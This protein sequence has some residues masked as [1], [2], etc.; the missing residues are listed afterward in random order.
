MKQV[1]AIVLGAGQRGAG[2][3][4]D[5]ALQ[6]PN[7]LKIVG[8]AEPRKDRREAFAKAHH[9]PESVC[10]ESWEEVFARPQFADCVFVCTQDKMHYIPVMTALR[11]GYHVLCE[12]PMSPNR[13]EL[14]AMGDMAKKTG[15]ILSICH[16][17][18]Y[19][20]FF[21]KIKE[22]LDAGLLGQL[23]SIQHIESVGYWHMAHSFVRGNWR[24]AEETSPMILAKC[25]HDTDILAWLAES[26]CVSVSSFGS[27]SHFHG[28]N[29]PTDA[30]EYC[31]DGCPQRDACPYYAP[32][33]YL[34]HPK[35]RPDGFVSV[36]SLDPSN[37]AVLDALRK[38]PYGRCVYR[39]DND[40]VDNQVVNLLF[41][42]GVS[43][44][45]TVCAFTD[46][47]ERII[48]LMGSHGQLRGNME[49]GELEL[50]DFAAGNQTV[51]HVHAPSGGHSGSD[52]SMMRNFV[53][54]VAR[55]GESRSSARQSV[56]SHL[57]ALAAE[58]SRKN[59]GQPVDIRQ[60]KR[61]N[62]APMKNALQPENIPTYDGSNQS[63]HPSVVRFE[64]PWHGYRYW[65]AMTPYP[66]NNDGFEDPSILASNDG[67]SWVV[68]KG[69]ANPLTPAPEVGHN[70]DVEL[71]YVPELEE[72]RIY[73]VEADDVKQS[74][75]KVMRSTDGIH[76][77]R[78]ETVIH[79]PVQKYSILSPTIQ[80]MADGSW[81]MWYVDTGN[82]GYICQNNKIRTRT[83]LDG[84]NWSEEET[85]DL[86]QPGWQIWHLTVWHE[87]QTGVLHA[88]YPAYPNGTNCDY[89]QLF[90]AHTLP[91]GTWKTYEKPLMVQ[92]KEEGWDDF[93]LY[94]TA[95]LLNRQTDL[96]RLWYGGKKKSDASWG[97]GY[98]EGI[99]SEILRKLN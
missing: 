1:T 70:C 71:V 39:C 72:L 17:L 81:R 53:A 42:N 47:C 61:D 91:D 16:V 41:E 30:P 49:T 23:I 85:V 7:E 45:M 82:T 40:V 99:Y 56:E 43:A 77:T 60:W 90:Y 51:F 87:R 80:Q 29:A 93:C 73:Y 19:S 54:L 26:P 38:G 46:R 8:V 31:L 55:G 79:D 34:E 3:Y 37:E 18:R 24:K 57:I 20:P 13:N 83:S 48:N 69:V 59:G 68:P 4:A 28:A 27:L 2:V 76:W 95:F 22:I 10:F 5:Y 74:W 96:L 15:R 14:V 58:E 64:A 32:R 86:E 9:L 84:L 33:F 35:A 21:V 36:V 6:F 98:T 75:V 50:M 78:P 92:G 52:V 65:M 94:R 66:H 44:S 97:I 67:K 12:K 62:A 63:T 88:I 89:C 25:C 11:E